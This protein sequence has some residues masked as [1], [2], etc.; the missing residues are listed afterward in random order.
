MAFQAFLSNIGASIVDPFVSIWLWLVK[1]VPD[2]IAAI[3]ILIVGYLVALAVSAVLEKVL[4]RIK[5]DEWVFEKTN[6]SRAIGK[7]D[8]T[9]V[10]GLVVKWYIIVLFLGATAARIQLK[11][12]SEFLAS[13][14]V[15]IPNVIVAVIIGLIG[16]LAGMYVEKKVA[17]TKAKGSKIVGAIA[18]WVIYVFTALIVL[19]QV[20]VQVAMAQ[21][22]FL[23]ILG[24]IVL[25]L[26]LLIGIS[27]GLAFRDDAKK[28]ISDVKKKL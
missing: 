9:H 4:R 11:T 21:N 12:L 23:I 13:L 10:L 7:F 1:A 17:E 2:I 8:L 25:M 19:D 16:I 27:F 28:I 6:M 18:K 26:A 20:G 14:A 5:F 24:G 3:V 15:W 22:S